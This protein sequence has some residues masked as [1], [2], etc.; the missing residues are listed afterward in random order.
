MSPTDT[1]DFADLLQRH[2]RQRRLTQEELAERAGISPAAVS[3]L[4]RG[5]THSPQ[6]ATL[7]MLSAALALT[8]DEEATFFAAARRQLQ[9][10]GSHGSAAAQAVS[11]TAPGA[12]LGMELPLPF[13]ALVGRERDQAALLDLLVRPTTR[14]LTLTGP[15]GVGKT[16]LALELAAMLRR[17][18]GQDVVF[19]GLIPVQEPERVLPAIAHALGIRDSGNLPL[20]DALVH[21]LR[22]RRMV[23]VLDN[24][25]QVLP[26]ARS[27]L[28]LLVA[29]PHVRA[30]VTSRASLNV[31]G[32]RCYPVSPLAL[33]EP[34]QMDSVD[35]LRRVPTVALFVERASAVQPEFDITTIEE[36]RLVVGICARL[37]GLPLA[38]ELAAARIRHFGL[39]ELH[40]RLTQPAFLGVLAEGPQDLADHQRTMRSTIAWSHDLLSEP[41]RQL[42]RRLSVFAG[43]ATLEAVEAVCGEPGHPHALD[44]LVSL[45]DK[46]LVT[47]VGISNGEARFGMLET[48]HQFARE[49]LEASGESDSVRQWHADYFQSFAEQAAQRLWGAGQA[50]A[51]AQLE[52]DHENLRA[53]LRWTR[54]HPDVSL[55]FRLASALL[56]F[57]LLRGPV[58]EGRSHLDA[59]LALPQ[60]DEDPANPPLRARALY[61]AGSLAWKQSDYDQAVP[62]LQ[63]ALQLA[64]TCGQMRTAAAALHDLANVATEQNEFERAVALYEESLAL[65]RG[66]ADS[67]GVATTLRKLAELELLQGHFARTKTFAEESLA[68]CRQLGDTVGA[69]YIL[70]DLGIAARYEGDHEQAA[71]LLEQAL[72]L[73]RTLN[74]V[75]G[76]GRTLQHLAAV[77]QARGEYAKARDLLQESLEWYRTLADP[78]SL[79][80]CLEAFAALAR[81]EG[82][83]ECAARLYATAA[84]Q[85]EIL[86]APYSPTERD[87]IEVDLATLRVAIEE[88]AFAAAW[89]AGRARTL[90]EAF[91]ELKGS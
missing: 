36:G 76:I 9:P 41:E 84:A 39:R 40:D 65:K 74:D 78:L 79:A 1:P 47:R 48:I 53:A 56:R 2:R 26:A 68:L 31:R 71:I 70:A 29:C 15:A 58:S 35:E 88:P 91:A 8:A 10:D 77:T 49:Q 6:K 85:R 81:A 33:P 52:A 87:L 20:R 13:T 19:V 17:E 30:L 23:L 18:R 67:S 55:G 43:G 61:V 73:Q 46:S 11:R 62:L 63:T 3:L 66:L 12:T 60:G 50:E 59:I 69:A 21:A 34:T 75:W 24:F 86:G 22:E 42:F 72:A 5:L 38:I 57:W 90:E 82:Q 54:T 80:E 27:V 28:E 16:R 4:E 32:E 37:D 51:L 25:E 44:D 64:R 83:P 89:A 14:L 7:G 45:V